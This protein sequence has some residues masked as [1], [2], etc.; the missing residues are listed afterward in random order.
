LGKNSQKS[1][2]R[3]EIQ[4]HLRDHIRWLFME[5]LGLRQESLDRLL[6]RAQG[7][8]P[9]EPGRYVAAEVKLAIPRGLAV[10]VEMQGN[11]KLRPLGS[12]IAGERCVVKIQQARAQSLG[13]A[14]NDVE[15][16]HLLAF[17]Q[18]DEAHE[19]QH[20][21]QIIKV[22][23]AVLAVHLGEQFLAFGCDCMKPTSSA[24]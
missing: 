13:L 2:G 22:P 1:D 23:K 18:A 21:G 6:H 12:E 7:S 8:A 9:G 3:P 14:V 11:E 17:R 4:H 5:N 20:E 16:F 19:R 10:I 15:D 24:S